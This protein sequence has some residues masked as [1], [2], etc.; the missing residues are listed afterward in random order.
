MALKHLPENTREES[1]AWNLQLGV[2]RFKYADLNRVRRIEALDAAFL[3]SLRDADAALAAEFIRYRDAGERGWERLQESELLMRVAPHVAAFIARLFNIEADYDALCERVRA[4]QSVF[5][6][7]RQVIERGLLKQPPNVDEVARLDPIEL[8]FAYREVVATVMPDATLIAD[9]ERELAVVT[10]ALQAKLDAARDVPE[11][12]T[13]STQ[14]AA[15]EA[16]TRAI[17]FHPALAARRRSFICFRVPGK[18]D[19]DD[20]VPRIR[21]RAD[22]P[23]FFM[24]PPEHRRHRDGFD[25]TD[26]R[27]TP[28]ENLREAHYC[29][30]CHERG[31]D[32]CTTGFHAKDGS[33]QRNPLGI[34]L[35]GCP[36]D[37]KVSEMIALYRDGYPLGALA[38]I[39]I[40]NPMLAGTGHRIC[41][42]CMKACIF[43]KQDPVNI[44]QIETGILTEVLRLPYGFEIVSLLTRWNPLN[45]RRPYPLRY[46]GKNVLIVGM[47]PAGYTLAQHL[48]NEGFGVVG[49]EGLKVE[50]LAMQFR[51]A[52]RRVPR[53]IRDVNEIIGPL[54]ERPTLGFGGV[55]EYGI[56]VRWDKN[57]LD[58]NY[59]MLMRRKKFRLLDGVRFG[60]TLAI[61]DAWNLGFDHI[62]ITAGA[63]RPTIVP[64]QNN[65]ARGVRMASDFLMALQ[66][67][68]A[69]RKNSLTNLQIELPAVVIGGGLTA[70]D[71]ATELQ[72]Y[73]VTQVEKTLE[74]FERLKHRIGEDA[75]WAK[76]DA[77]EARTVRT[78]LD[79]GRMVQAERAAARA[80][81]RPTDF[82]RLVRGWGG[83]TIVY[84]KRLQDAPA[85]RLNHEEIIKSLEEGIGFI[86]CLSPN[87]CVLDEFGHAQT[88][89]CTRQRLVDGKWKDTGEVVNLP[90]RQVIVAAGTNPNV[91]YERE[92][93]G[94]FAIDERRACFAMHRVV[95][96]PDGTRRLEPV[97]DGGA[98]FFTS[99]QNGDRFVTFYG[100]AHPVFAGNV[101]KA[102][103]SARFGYREIARLFESEIAAQEFDEQ[104]ERENAWVRFAEVLD[105]GLRAIVV[106]AIRLADR[107]VE[108]IVRAPMAARNFQPGQF[109]RVQNYEGTAETVEGIRLT[110]EGVA[111]TGA[112]TDP[113][114]GLISLIV[115]EMGGSS[116]LCGILEPGEEIVLMGPTGTP[117]EIPQGETVLL[118]GGGLGNAVMFSIAAAMKARG[119]RVIYFAGYKRAG[120]LFKRR[121]IEEACDLVVW[122]VDEG[123]PIAPRRPQDRSVVGNIVQAM[124]RYAAGE[125]GETPIVLRDVHRLICIG[126]DRM[127]DAVRAARHGALRD[128]LPPDH[129]AIG[130]INSPMQCM[131]KEVCSQCLQRQVDPATGKETLVFSCFNQDQLLDSVDFRFLHERLRQNSA[132]EKLTSLWLDHLFEQREVQLV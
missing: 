75:I 93:P 71:T 65:L 83:V 74:R 114:R 10:L 57:F 107:I 90:A 113:A 5:E 77:E 79:H 125:L 88:L 68:G 7:K 103:A 1:R 34:P 126:S 4:D 108:V 35:A 51:G 127:M 17:G 115:L 69:Y 42:D 38:V 13:V 15:V 94:T 22:L 21:P 6:W 46:N 66:G 43:Q 63:G 12:A 82:A 129:I 27:Y 112:W 8:E 28:R 104:A 80:A 102:M 111:L 101:V 26:P 119:N 29:V 16:W 85:Y 45:A 89:R 9:P 11:R 32:S 30:T 120:D 49:I 25:L 39:M 84:R 121:Y 72:A 98:G 53:P 86:E 92:H 109:Y 118:A 50:P 110:M 24:G 105:N 123:T 70:I 36:L 2:P 56:T 117:T 76:L 20:L 122:S 99:Y 37:E 59:V 100:D 18:L 64:M 73:Y 14:L 60:G 62:A 52:K 95:D 61:D 3:L 106:D 41:N 132:A 33:V 78:W 48:L 58:I 81:G 31:R 130:S 47:G 91:V 67:Q 97:T 128:V 96:N 131:L 23:E 55:A 44:P 87:V 116:R 40:D 19:H 124:Q 54:S